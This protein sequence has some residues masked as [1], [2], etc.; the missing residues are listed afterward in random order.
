[1]LIIAGLMIL[2]DFSAR[3]LQMEEMLLNLGPCK[4]KRFCHRYRTLAGDQEELKKFETPC[5][6]NHTGKSW[7]LKMSALVNGKKVSEGNLSDMEWTF[8]ELIATG[9]LW[10]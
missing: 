3:T 7:K 2:N 10:S 1:M 6:K 5:Q 4:R 8:A 9:I